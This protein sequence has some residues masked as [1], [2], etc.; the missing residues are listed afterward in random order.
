MSIADNL[1]RVEKQISSACQRSNRSQEEVRLM[2]VSK[3]HPAEAILE[4]Y[5]AGMCLFGENRVQEYARKQPALAEAGIFAGRGS[6]QNHPTQTGAPFKPDSGLSGVIPGPPVQ[7]HCIGPVQSN[8]AA[9]AAQLFDAVDSVD[10]LRLAERL[11][12]AA[13]DAEKTLSIS[14]EIKLSPEPSKHGLMPDSVE[15]TE[16]L[17]HLPSLTHLRARG[18]M[19][20]PPFSNNPEAARPYFRELRELRESL[21]RRYPRLDLKELSMGMSH[22]FHVAI[23]EGATTVRIGTAIFGARPAPK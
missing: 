10:S 6:A 22:D 21:A 3:T 8:K 11:D 7:I 2:A 12:R 1:A 17:E 14:I 18:L 5:A 19:T 23:E 9:R 15:L 20:V 13:R 4:A 16:L